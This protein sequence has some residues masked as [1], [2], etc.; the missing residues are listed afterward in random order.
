[1]PTSNQA[2]AHTSPA[3]SYTSSSH[4][5]VPELPLEQSVSQLVDLF[6][7][8]AVPLH[9]YLEEHLS[10]H[11]PHALPGEVDTM[12]EQSAIAGLLADDDISDILINGPH[13]IYVTRNG[14]L[15]KTD[16]SFPGST[17]LRKLALAIAHSV[18]RTINA[19][20]PLVDARLKDGSR[21]NIIAPPMAVGGMTVSIRKFPKQEITLEDLVSRQELSEQMAEF[22][23]LCAQARVSMVISGGTG[24]GKTTLLNAISRFIPSTERIITIEDTAELRLQQPHVVRL[25]TKEPLN[26]GDRSQEVNASDLVRNALRMRPDRIIVGEVRGEEAYDMI[27]ALN[28]GHDG[29]LTTVHANAARD[30]FTRLENL[31]G[32]R[33]QNTAAESIR[34]QIV[35]A[36]NFIIQI[37]YDQNGV[38]RVASVTEIVGMEKDIPT[39][40]EIFSFK[41]DLVSDPKKCNTGNIGAASSR[42]IR[43]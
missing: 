32:P 34:R 42:I 25:E 10:A 29:S 17:A 8:I 26:F 16:V 35:S 20:R 28:T 1:M 24:T 19:D 13:E 38:R 23:R 9:T 5:P 39:M 31:M 40:Q 18:G 15:E 12:L 27:Q 14:Q 3:N 37:V 6:K 7:Q 30:A 43:D 22:L 21:V 33:L 36:L 4:A 41:E 2:P 11:A